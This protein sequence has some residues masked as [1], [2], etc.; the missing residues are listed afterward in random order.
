MRRKKNLADIAWRRRHGLVFRQSIFA[1]WS[2]TIAEPL[3]ATLL[4]WTPD[5]LPFREIA[6]AILC[7]ASDETC[8]LI[9]SSD[10]S[11]NG[12]WGLIRDSSGNEEFISVLTTGPHTQDTGSVFSASGNTFWLRSVLV[13]LCSRLSRPNA[14][15]E[16]ISQVLRHHQHT[17]PKNVMDAV[18]LSIEHVVLI[19]IKPDE[20]VQHTALL[21]LISIPTHLSMAPNEI[22]TQLYLEKLRQHKEASMKRKQEKR[23]HGSHENSLNSGDDSMLGY[24]SDDDLERELGE[25]NRKD[26]IALKPSPIGVEGDEASTFYALT[27]LFE[28]AAR[29]AMP[30]SRAREGRFPAEIY[31]EILSHVLDRTTRH[32]CMHVSRGFRTVCQ[33]E[34]LITDGVF[35]RPWKVKETSETVPAWFEMYDIVS[36]KTCKV[37]IRDNKRIPGRILQPV[38]MKMWKVVVGEETGRRSLIGEFGVCVNDFEEECRVEEAWCRRLREAQN[39]SHLS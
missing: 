2:S 29:R 4:Q 28:A 35:F 16:G 1:L 22:F 38:D 34:L 9:S 30:P 21:P 37:E 27:H 24:D 20:K 7:L 10:V 36:D 33:E 15:E 17:C 11:C 14:V 3:A 26:R 23:S 13:V 6:L 12:I 25:W 18:L 19:H 5:D 8:N 39:P 32:S 31:G